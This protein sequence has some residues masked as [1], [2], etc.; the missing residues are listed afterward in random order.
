MHAARNG[1]VYAT[2]PGRVFY[3]KDGYRYNCQWGQYRD[4]RPNRRLTTGFP[5]KQLVRYVA[6]SASLT[7]K[8]NINDYVQESEWTPLAM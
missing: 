7:D 2:D 6:R 3:A 8:V 4:D 1:S 5:Q